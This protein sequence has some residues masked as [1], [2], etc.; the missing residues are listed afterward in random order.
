MILNRVSIEKRPVVVD[1]R[2][3]IKIEKWKLSLALIIRSLAF[4]GDAIPGVIARLANKSAQEVE[5]TTI[6]LLDSIKE[7]VHTVNSD[8]GREF[9]KHESI[10][11]NLDAKFFFAHPYASWER[12]FNETLMDSSDSIS[13]KTLFN[14]ITDQQVQSVM[15]NLIT[16]QE[17]AGE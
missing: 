7:K 13:Q 17:N 9:A 10:V 6:N 15:E 5:R 12:E 3:R 14:Y 1:Q 16:V 2:S 4:S 8:N 11:K